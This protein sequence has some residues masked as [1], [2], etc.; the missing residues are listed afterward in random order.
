MA[1]KIRLGTLGLG[2]LLAAAAA[3]PVFA[4]TLLKA[5]CPCGYHF[6]FMAGGG[7]AN[8]KTLCAA[9]AYCPACKK[10]EILNYLDD[11]PQCQ[12]CAGTPVF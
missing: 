1:P 6:E 10:L 5:R 8:F 4:G 3:A 11:G 7:R 9:P 2:V 12:A